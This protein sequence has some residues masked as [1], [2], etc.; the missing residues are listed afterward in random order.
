MRGVLIQELKVG[1]LLYHSVISVSRL[2]DHTVISVSRLCYHNVIYVGHLFDHAVISVSRL[3][4]H[5]VISVSRLFD[6]T[7]ISVVNWPHSYVWSFVGEM[8]EWRKVAPRT[9]SFWLCWNAPKAKNG[10]SETRDESFRT[11]VEWGN[12]FKV[13]VW[14]LGLVNIRSDILQERFKM[15]GDCWGFVYTYTYVFVTRIYTCK[16]RYWYVCRS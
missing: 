16:W 8:F 4:Y 6:H 3:F 12:L 5:T 2:F 10:Q 1:Y 13:L 15:L 7:L 9:V 14:M 11:W